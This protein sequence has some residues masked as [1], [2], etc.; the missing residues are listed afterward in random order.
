ME[1]NV[2]IGDAFG[3][4]L[5]NC[6]CNR[7]QQNAFAAPIGDAPNHLELVSAHARTFVSLM[8]FFYHI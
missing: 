4:G 5:G 7:Q 6:N 3:G 8:H 2:P 1:F